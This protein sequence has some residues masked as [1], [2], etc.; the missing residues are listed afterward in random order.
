MHSSIVAPQDSARLGVL[1]K[2]FTHSGVCGS[3]I[4][5]REFDNGASHHSSSLERSG[6][7]GSVPELQRSGHASSFFFFDRVE[8]LPS[9]RKTESSSVAVEFEKVQRFSTNRAL[10]FKVT[11]EEAPSY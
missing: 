4:P 9:E 1:I 10:G 6:I 2:R 11:K 7:C 8:I 5:F 3:R